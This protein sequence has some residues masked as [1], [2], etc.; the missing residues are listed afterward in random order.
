MQPL[1]PALRAKATQTINHMA[2]KALRCLAFAQKTDLGN[3]AAHK[4]L[5]VAGQLNVDCTFYLHLRS[6]LSPVQSKL[7]SK[8]PHAFGLHFTCSHANYRMLDGVMSTGR[9]CV[10]G[11]LSSYDGAQ[12]SSHGQ[13]TEPS[14]YIGIE[15]DLTLLGFAGL[16]DP[17]RGEVAGAVRD[18]QLAGI[19]VRSC[20][21]SVSA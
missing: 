15:K 8:L 2:E 13:L 14:N 6:F 1:S 20:P 5:C 16:E 18:C 9:V 21:H 17:P 19:R 10:A 7:Q 12:H 4:M 11:D 3:I